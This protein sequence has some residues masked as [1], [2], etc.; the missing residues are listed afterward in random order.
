MIVSDWEDIRKLVG[1]HHV[2]ANEK[3]ATRLAILAGIDM[4]MV[5]SD[6][7]F[8]DLLVQLVNEKTVPMSRIDDAVGRILTLKARVGLLDALRQRSASDD[9]GRFAASR[10]VALR[11]ARESIV[12]AK[13]S[14]AVLPLGSSTRVLLTGPTADSQPALNN[15]WTITWL[16]DRAPL[17]PADRPTVRRALEARLGGRLTYVPGSTY[18]KAIDVQAAAT[19][20][21]SADVVVLCLGE[22]SY[23]ETPG[24]IDDL[25]LPDAQL[26]LAEAVLAAGKPVVL[27][28]IEGRP[29]IIR[30]LADRAAGIVIALNP[31]ME[32]GTAITDV[33][34]GEVNPS[35]RLPI[36]YPRFPNALFTYDYK[37]YDD[38]D[39]TAPSTSFKP[40]FAFGSGSSYTTFEY[41]G[42]TADGK[43]DVRSGHRCVGDG[44]KHRETRRHRSRPAVRFRSCRQ[45]DPTDQAPQAVHAGRSAGRR[46][47]GSPV[48]PH[49]ERL[50]VHRHNRPVRQRAGHVYHRGRWADQ[51]CRDAIAETT[52][53]D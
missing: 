26:H 33:L 36:T 6:Y 23:A 49:T 27:L 9:H 42:L 19:A 15:G 34:S 21:A 3:E 28:M 43:G 11:A 39:L 20:A 25:Q 45:R 1:M 18:D 40:Q 22:M 53:D 24:N 12:L 47:E 17:Y 50:V 13:N 4:S 10:Q 2:A 35:G 31:G 7:S 30:T 37:A 51:G 52:V 41:A 29:R 5:P 14:A 46:V 38:H 32:G 16:G 8:S 44:S 48:P